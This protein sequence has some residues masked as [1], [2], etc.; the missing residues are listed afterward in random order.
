VVAAIRSN[1]SDI[2]AE[3]MRLAGDGARF[4][5][6]EERAR[7]VAGSVAQF[8]VDRAHTGAEETTRLP[9]TRTVV[10]A[11]TG[12]VAVWNIAP[13]S[14]VHVRFGLTNA[15]ARV[16]LPI[17]TAAR[18][19][20]RIGGARV[21]LPPGVPAVIDD[22]FE[23]ELSHPGRLPAVLL[24]IDLRHP[25]MPAFSDGKQPRAAHRFFEGF[26]KDRG[27][28][29]VVR[30]RGAV[31]GEFESD[32]EHAIGGR[33]RDAGAREVHIRNGR[34]YVVTHGDGQR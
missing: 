12:L 34:L 26:L 3:I 30:S 25:D 1:Y 13:R 17:A 32:A 29:R 7:V 27:L 21:K 33:M 11:G 5:P 16:Y 24:V 2:A 9:A 28:S 20:L 6:P 4:G 22:G 23:H 19:E 14:H 18:T 15:R 31:V 8:T 10:A